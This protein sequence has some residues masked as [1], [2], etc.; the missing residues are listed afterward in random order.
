M[1]FLN[2]I[3]V[4]TRSFL[5][6][7][8]TMMLAI[9]SILLVA[10]P[11]SLSDPLCQDPPPRPTDLP[12]YSEC[13]V[14]VNAIFA[15]ADQQHD[16]PILWSENPSATIRSRQ[17]PHSYTFPLLLNNCEFVVGTI[18]DDEDDIFPTRLI[19][20]AAG[21]I[22]TL[23][24]DQRQP[25][26]IGAELVGPKGVIAVAMRKRPVNGERVSGGLDLLNVT[27]VRLSK[28]GSLSGLPSSLVEDG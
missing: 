24:L 19:A 15:I 5:L 14:L 26:T 22:A 20:A 7:S 6:V 2:D 28:P 4:H 18:Q 8:P 3:V 23:C 12:I 21:R 25:K 10:L 9:L 11:F 17:L 13:Q 16:A 27:N 1:Q